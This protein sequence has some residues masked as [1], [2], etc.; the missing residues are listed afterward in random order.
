MSRLRVQNENGTVDWFSRQ[1]T[2]VGLVNSHSVHVSI[3][4]EPNDLVTEQ[5]RV[6]LRI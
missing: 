5:L 1:I 2:L 6:I 4:N 3:V